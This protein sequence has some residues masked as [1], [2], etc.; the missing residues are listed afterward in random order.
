M[1]ISQDV[2]NKI[3]YHKS[4]LVLAFKAKICFFQKLVFLKKKLQRNG[5]ILKMIVNKNFE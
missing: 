3:F 5:K 2:D 4:L 1:A